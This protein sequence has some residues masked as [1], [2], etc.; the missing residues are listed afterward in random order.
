MQA[1]P[2]AIANRMRWTDFSLSSPPAPLRQSK[3]AKTAYCQMCNTLRLYPSPIARQIKFTGEEVDDFCL[4]CQ[5]CYTAEGAQCK[6]TVCVPL[7]TPPPPPCVVNCQR[8]GFACIN[9]LLC[10]ECCDS[11]DNVCDGCRCCERCTPTEDGHPI[12]CNWCGPSFAIGN[13]GD[14]GQ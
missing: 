4:S 12:S 10:P 14:G 6:C 9:C 8:R 3:K 11:I 13:R 1:M 2:P 7:E 5:Q